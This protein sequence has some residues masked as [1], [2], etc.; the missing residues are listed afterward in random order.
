M[1]LNETGN[2]L[3]STLVNGYYDATDLTTMLSQQLNAVAGG[4]VSVSLDDNTKKFTI[5][6]TNNFYFTF[7]TNTSNSARKLLGFNASDGTNNTSHT[8]DNCIDLNTYKNVFID[9]EQ[10]DRH[11]IN[12]VGYY[13]TSLIINGTGTFGELFRYIPKD[14]I[15]QYIH[16]TRGIKKITLRFHD[17]NNSDI[18]INS[19]YS[20]VLQAVKI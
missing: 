14:N 19:D 4:T 2:D 15:D 7:G 6:N 8:S 5:T 10:N 18:S 9:I 20:I 13:N 1:Y 12:S 16:F 17:N 11:N 3:V